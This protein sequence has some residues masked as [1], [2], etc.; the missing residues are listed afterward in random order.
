MD[1]SILKLILLAG[2][3]QGFVLALLLATRQ[4][5]QP[6]NRLLAVLLILL[7][8]HLVLVGFDER[9]FMMKYAY[10]SH[11][12]WV[13]PALYGPLVLLFLR[14]MTHLAPSFSWWELLYFLPFLV[15]FFLEL[16]YFLASPEAKRAY[17]D[18]YARSVEDDFGLVNQLVNF[19]H[20]VFFG[21]CILL[22]RKH[23]RRIRDFYSD[24]SKVRMDWMGHFLYISFGIVLFS[25]L[26]FYAR[27][28]HWPF[29]GA[30][31]PWHFL[32]VVAIIYWMAYRA[33]AQPELFSAHHPAP[34]KE[35]A[36]LLVSMPYTAVLPD[37]GEAQP[38]QALSPAARQALAQQL[39]A[40]MEQGKRFLN[41]DL[42]LQDLT[43]ELQTN[44]QYVS[45]TL[46]SHLGKNFYDFVNDY[47]IAEFQRLC[48][49][50]AC[51]H[52]TILALAYDSGFNSKA[53]FN[54]VFK[55]KT[56]L[57]PSAYLR[58]VKPEWEEE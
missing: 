22:Y 25:I 16:P 42:T 4:G 46:N 36:P 39:T 5:N 13:L 23:L 48:Q 12:S 54:A 29:F 7:S 31:Y 27:K 33:L 19:I 6:A 14:R 37:E 21:L 9:A 26:V 52:L 58:Q 50:P 30:F 15:V 49:D 51:R 41:S 18:D 3:L 2:A 44:R 20:V 47:R 10:L 40:L 1:I 35:D 53:T 34:E 57:T 24:L 43:D 11:V 56:G 38:S 8:F 45:E 28:F 32:R 17:L 55:K